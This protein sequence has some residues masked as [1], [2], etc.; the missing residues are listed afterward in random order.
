MRFILKSA[1]WLGLVA[2]LLPFGGGSKETAA[3]ITFFGTLAGAEEALQDL[4]GFCGRAPQA[5]A[6][7][8]EFAVFAGER[9]GDGIQMAYGLVQ[10]QTG[11]ADTADAAAL[12]PPPAETAS[13]AP[14]A[15]PFPAA[16]P[17]D[18]FVTGAVKPAGVA[19]ARRP[20]PSMPPRGIAAAAGPG[21]NP[22][23]PPSPSAI[24]TPTP[25]PRA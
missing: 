17:A 14:P 12:A 3:N 4:T 7:G 25:A 24:P 23:P 20:A 1:F 5:C 16:D 21:A 2:F 6:T 10:D 11:R 9:I 15:S 22:S 19:A 13:A 8:R 18:L